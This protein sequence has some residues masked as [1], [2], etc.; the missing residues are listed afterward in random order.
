MIT[1]EK[2]KGAIVGGA[3]G[4]A[5]GAPVEKLT[6][7]QIRKLYGK[8]ESLDTEHY[9]T[10]SRTHGKGFGRFTDD[11]LM[12]LLLCRVYMELQSHLDAYSVFPLIRKIYF[13]EI[14]IPEFQKKMPL[15]E[16]LFYPEKYLFLSNFLANRDPRSGGVGNM[17]NC[18]AAMYISPVG[19]VNAGD[20]EN[21]YHEAI[22]FASAHQ[23]SYGLE[24]AGVYAAC[25]ATAMIPGIEIETILETAL[26]LSKDGTKMAIEA[27]LNAADTI[28]DPETSPRVFQEA[29][30][31]YSSIG[32]DLQRMPE[33]IGVPSDNY[34]PSRTKSIE[35]L[36][37]ALGYIALHKGNFL[38]ALTGGVNSG[39]DTDSIG[40]MIGTILGAWHGINGINQKFVGQLIDA[41]QY[42]LLQLSEEFTKTILEI[43]R[44]DREK[45]EKLLRIRQE[46]HREVEKHGNDHR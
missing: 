30:K 19:L 11:T 26:A 12:T 14:W 2:V 23:T 17:V 8:V 15:I 21:A 31:P 7:E 42:D 39:R 40:C 35:E 36:P 29:I 9:R 13:E 43:H 10:K 44:K 28:R 27:V 4:D 45:Q 18:G 20:P 3:L 41:N 34:A 24:A 16:R 1:Q 46:L 25:V 33:K 32:D 38:N 5:W 22:A 37:I 6:A